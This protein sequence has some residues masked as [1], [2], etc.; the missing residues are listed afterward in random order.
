MTRIPIPVHGF[1]IVS[2]RQCSCSQVLHFRNRAALKPVPDD[3][4]LSNESPKI[5]FKWDVE[6]CSTTSSAYSAISVASSSAV[7]MS[8]LYSTGFQDRGD[9]CTPRKGNWITTDS[10]CKLLIPLFICFL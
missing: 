9:H 8:S 10:E 5:S 4:E 1:L 6:S 2:L 3:D 7:G